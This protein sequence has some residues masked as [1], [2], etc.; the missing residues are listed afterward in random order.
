LFNAQ[1]N[2]Q[3]AVVQE[4][5]NK[6]STTNFPTGFSNRRGYPDISALGHKYFIT[7]NQGFYTVSGTSA[8]APVVAGMISLVNAA[9][10]SRGQSTFGFIN[11]WLYANAGAVVNDISS[12]NNFCTASTTCCAQGYRASSGWDPVTGLG[13]INFQSFY[14]AG[15][16]GPP[17]LS[18]TRVATSNR[19]TALPI[20]V[21][22]ER[23]TTIPTKSPSASPS[24][25]PSFSSTS[26]ETTFNPST[27]PTAAA[28]ATTATSDI[29]TFV[30]TVAPIVRTETP[31]RRRTLPPTTAPLPSR[32]PT[33]VPTQTPTIRRSMKPTVKPTIKPT[34]KP[35]VKPTADPTRRRQPTIRPT[36]R[37]P[38]KT[39]KLH[40]RPKQQEQQVEKQMPLPLYASAE[41][42]SAFH[43]EGK[44]V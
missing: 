11:P 36:A 9:R 19:P 5:F 21:P 3:S 15:I 18:P 38:T 26:R 2:W 44:G 40:K 29:P 30:P 13:V 10:V 20:A 1:P 35:T 24:F 16:A 41:S 17:T 28:A 37:P 27:V 4:Y 43:P 34:V 12:G 42:F 23:P 6:V 33:K 25:G 7:L 32:R 22:T 31:S 8:S 39:Q 14:N